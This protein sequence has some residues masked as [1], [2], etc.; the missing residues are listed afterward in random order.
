MQECHAENEAAPDCPFRAGVIAHRPL[1]FAKSTRYRL[2]TAGAA[3]ACARDDG[4]S[5]PRFL[6]KCM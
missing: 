2:S 1:G 5:W 6:L 3:F 4:Q